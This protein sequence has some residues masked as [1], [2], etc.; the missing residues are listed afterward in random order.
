VSR[1]PGLIKVSR[2]LEHSGADLELKPLTHSQ[3]PSSLVLLIYTF[4]HTFMKSMCL[5]ESKFEPVM[6]QNTCILDIFFLSS[7]PD[8]WKN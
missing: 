8:V 3:V 1:K 2:V 6:Y 7:N 5:I 4:E